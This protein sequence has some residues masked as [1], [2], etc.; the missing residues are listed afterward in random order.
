MSGGGR[1]WLR[2]AATA[3]RERY[4]AG[5]LL[6]AAA[7]LGAGAISWWSGAPAAAGALWQVT[8]LAG[9]LPSLGWT[10]AALRRGRTGVDLIAVL[11]LAGA[12][13]TGEHF[14]G[15][16]ITLMLASGRALEALARRRASHDLR[17]LAS[18]APRFARRRGPSGTERVPVDEVAPGD[19]LLVA[20]GELVP[21]D[22][23]VDGATAVLDESLVTGESWQVERPAG[24]PVRSGT[25]NAGDAFAMTASARADESTYAGI[26]RL[27]REAGAER[28][29]AV[30]AADHY[31]SWFLPLALLLAALAWQLQGSPV[32]AVAV[33]VV[34]TPCPLLL[35]VPI[36]LVAGLSRASR[37]GAI[38]RD[39]DALE[40]LARARTVLLDKTGTLT[41]G[42]PRVARVVASPA[43]SEDE[44]LRLA[45]SLEQASS[46]LVA[47][48]ILGEAR[49][50]G[51]RLLA[52]E[53]AAEQP[54]RGISGV[55]GGARIE[56]GGLA[57]PEHRPD[58]VAE[59]ESTAERDASGVAWVSREGSL[60]GAL[61]LRDRPRDDAPQAVRRL[62][63]AGVRRVVM[64]TGDRPDVARSVA[65]T[66]GLDD[67]LASRT[68]TG[69]VA[70][71]RAESRLATTAMVGDGINDAPALAAADVGVAMGARGAT[72][73]SEAADVVLTADR[74]AALADCADVAVRARRIAAQSAI[75]GM[76]L[77]LLAM[78]AAVAGA[79]APAPGAVLQEVIDVAVILNSLRVLAAP[80]RRRGPVGSPAR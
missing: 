49:R 34:A 36:A 60:S 70:A 21:V 52:P 20:T 59:V 57:L 30:R 31:A 19:P 35:A 48:P 40:H 58:W 10:I 5:L 28:A 25:V 14:A 62:R 6:L 71:V 65:E 53:R 24:E 54:G 1:A 45:A 9:V 56:V 55:V 42:R 17:A 29:P 7:L 79:L 39:G 33:L 46:H 47:E 2:R 51:L 68:P 67:V 80:A 15:A 18:A 76:F 74:L 43:D 22:G 72:A 13:V 69:K 32:A 41:E 78:V 38:V 64:L 3:V 75:T 44:V 27:A 63:A 11:S 77:S 23:V 4:E 66:V 26:A 50:R 61:V 12:W 37:V 8:T 73:S 16:L